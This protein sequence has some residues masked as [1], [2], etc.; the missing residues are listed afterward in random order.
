MSPAAKPPST[1]AR[2]YAV[3][4]RIPRGRV[5]NYGQVSELAGLKGAARQVGYALA[6]LKSGTD[7][8][9]HRVVNAA[10]GISV[11]AQAGGKPLQRVMLESE[12]VEFDAAG[13]V[14]M[15]RYR[16]RPRRRTIGSKPARGEKNGR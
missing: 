4:A 9:W 6:A 10:G 15:N 3:V 12:G 1:Y 2:I 7:L 14:N 8:P 5:A 13:R 16:W 11:R